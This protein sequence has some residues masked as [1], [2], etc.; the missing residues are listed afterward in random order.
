MKGTPITLKGC[1]TLAAVLILGP[2]AIGLTA[3]GWLEW[4]NWRSAN[5]PPEKETVRLPV[6]PS[7]KWYV[8]GTLHD[9]TPDEWNAASQ[10]NKLATCA[11][12]LAAARPT[13][14]PS[15]GDKLKDLDSDDFRNMAI[16]LCADIDKSMA[17]KGA[18]QSPKD[19]TKS[20]LILWGWV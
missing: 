19:I 5:A 8:G 13:L 4:Q 2:L 7:G 14:K 1:A 16:T 6:Q 11:D 15:I 3:R 17:V 10:S 12:F 9:A 20:L 18:V